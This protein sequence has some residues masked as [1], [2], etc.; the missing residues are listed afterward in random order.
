MK[1]W[2]HSRLACA[3]QAKA[4]DK[5]AFSGTG[6]QPVSN[7]KK[8]CGPT[9]TNVMDLICLLVAGTLKSH[10]QAVHSTLGYLQA[11]SDALTELKATFQIIIAGDINYA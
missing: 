9:S 3:V 1:N 7:S 8:R 4:F 5:S 11:M 6:F 10:P 2:W